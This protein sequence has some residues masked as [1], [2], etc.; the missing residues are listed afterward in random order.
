[1]RESCANPPAVLLIR[2]RS[3]Q[4]GIVEEVRQA[5]VQF[6]HAPSHKNVVLTTQPYR[7]IK[8]YPWGGGKGLIKARD[9][10]ITGPA[11]TT[12]RDA[13]AAY[14]PA[15]GTSVAIAPATLILALISIDFGVYAKNKC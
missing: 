10:V 6:F 14:P 5:V 2:C 1:M 11:N 3:K 13:A 7:C 15:S 4:S 8:Y 9:R 12:Q